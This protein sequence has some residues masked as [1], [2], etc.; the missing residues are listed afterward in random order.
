MAINASILDILLKV[1]KA[2]GPSCRML[3]LG[4]SDMLVTEQQLSALCGADILNRIN[5]RDDSE[6]ILKWHRLEGT[7]PRL[8][9]THSLFKAMN[10]DTE[11]VDIVA[12][13]GCEIVMDLNEPS[14]EEMHGKYDVVYDGGTM[15]HCFNIGQV[16]RNI[17]AMTRLGGFIVHLNPINFFNHGFFNFNPT[18]YYDFYTQSGNRIVSDFHVLYGPVF[19]SQMMTVP[20]IAGGAEVPARSVVLV[21]AQ[22]TSDAIPGW[23]MQSKYLHTPNLKG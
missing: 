20:P 2:V 15:E 3:S 19:A 16:M 22:K 4:Y 12:S 17:H 11:F 5:F 7:A 21:I 1:T 13:R 8:A 10:I 23:P 9:E 14:A 6:A 18:F